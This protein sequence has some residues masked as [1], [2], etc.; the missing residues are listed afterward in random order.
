VLDLIV[1]SVLSGSSDE[2]KKSISDF[3]TI[4][5]KNK[6]FSFAPVPLFGWANEEKCG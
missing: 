4:N 2:R 5:P 3:K 6:S 1:F